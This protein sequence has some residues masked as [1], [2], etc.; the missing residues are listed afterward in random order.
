MLIGSRLSHLK[1]HFR[2]VHVV[3]MYSTTKVSTR[4]RKTKPVSLFLLTATR[5]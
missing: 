4:R 3:Q 5:R 2:R 1:A